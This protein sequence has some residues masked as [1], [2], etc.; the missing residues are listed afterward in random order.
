MKLA[1]GKLVKMALSVAL[2]VSLVPLMGSHGCRDNSYYGGFDY[3][4]DFLP[5]WGGG[6]DYYEYGYEEAYVEFG[7]YYGGGGYYDDGYYGGGYY[8]DWWWKG[9][10]ADKPARTR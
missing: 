10:K 1:N 6:Y 9:K 8:D 3:V 2:V 7:G 4:Y 5:S